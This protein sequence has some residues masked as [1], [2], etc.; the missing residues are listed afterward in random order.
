M[1]AGRAPSVVLSRHRAARLVL[2]WGHPALAGDAALLVS[3]LA[4]NALL[5]G[6]IR[7]RLFRVHLGLAAHVLRIAVSD[8]RGERLPSIRRPD[9]DDCYGR[10]RGRGRGLLIVAQLADD[11]GIEPRTVGKTV[12]AELAVR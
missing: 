11:W 1:C 9:A 5:H 8:P 10:G 2:P 12:L 4:T 6:A 3:E 7:G